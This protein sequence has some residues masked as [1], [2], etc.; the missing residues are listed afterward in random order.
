[1][2]TTSRRGIVNPREGFRHFRLERHAPAA[3]LA[4]WVERHW[5]VAWDL[6]G[7]APF[8]QAVIP[9]PSVQLVSEP[10]G[11]RV[12]GIGTARFERRL[13]GR[14]MAVGTKFRPGAFAPFHGAPAWRLTDAVLPV[15]DVFGA[16]GAALADTIARGG[17]TVE[18]HIGAVEAFL[19][20][21]RPAPDSN[22]ATLQRMIAALLA[23]PAGL[24]AAELAE[25]YGM[26]QRTLQRLFRRYV[27]VGPKWVL[28]RY[29]V[30][31]AA[32]LLADGEHDDWAAMA[33]D[34][35]YFDQAHFV[36]DFRAVVGTTPAQYVAA[37]A[38]AREEL[39]GAAA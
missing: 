34:L 5:V 10:G 16:D 26:S 24:R 23:E 20:E 39:A 21:R 37:C 3:A 9:H 19:L 15:A 14:G 25:R 1:M 29:R 22:V 33:V 6:R 7:R 17:G 30:H 18:A 2:E 31:Q 4:P 36:N 35:G 8:T 32:E 13:E 27:G 28:Q 12:H 11:T 38:A